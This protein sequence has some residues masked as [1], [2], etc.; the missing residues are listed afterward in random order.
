MSLT[1]SFRLNRTMFAFR[2]YNLSPFP[3]RFWGN[4][5]I[6]YYGLGYVIGFLAGA[7]LLFRYARAGRS[8]VALAKIPELIAFGGQLGLARSFGKVINP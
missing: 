7:W 5:G 6:R 3:I 4:F 8:L 1:A 2:V